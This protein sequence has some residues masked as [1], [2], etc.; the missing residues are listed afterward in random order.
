MINF[1][2]ETITFTSYKHIFSF[3]G[4]ISAVSGTFYRN[5]TNFSIICTI[6]ICRNRAGALPDFLLKFF[7]I[8]V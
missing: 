8:N 7:K 4:C 6:S 2:L 1:F 3:F 5:L